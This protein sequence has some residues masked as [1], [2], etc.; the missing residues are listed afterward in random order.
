MPWGGVNVRMVAMKQATSI[1]FGLALLLP[2]LGWAEEGSDHYGHRY[3]EYGRVRVE[4]AIGDGAGQPYVANTLVSG[5]N[6]NFIVSATTGVR[7]MPIPDDEP[8][9]TS[10]YV[11]MYAVS[12]GTTTVSSEVLSPGPFELLEGIRFAST[13]FA[14][15]ASIPIE[16][17]VIFVLQGQGLPDYP[18]A[19]PP[20]VVNLK[21]YNKALYLATMEYWS[22]TQFLKPDDQ[23]YPVPCQTADVAKLVI[24]AGAAKLNGTTM[25]H[26]TV[27][28]NGDGTT[29]RESEGQNR[30][31][32]NLSLATVMFACTHG[33]QGRFRAS[34]ADEL[35]YSPTYSNEV[36]TY[37]TSKP[38]T[39]RPPRD[40]PPYNMAFFYACE[41]LAGGNNA[42]I[43]F[44]LLG[45]GSPGEVFPNKAY[46]GFAGK[47]KETLYQPSTETLE[48]H[49]ERLMSFLMQGYTV[50]DALRWTQ[51]P[52][53]NP[54]AKR[55]RSWSDGL[56]D[57]L[58]K[59]D[60]YARLVNV[61][62]S[63]AELAIVNKEVLNR[64]WWVVWQS[65]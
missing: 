32:T 33:E 40:V 10:G 51:D 21:A 42:P 20:V 52:N 25:N 59:G 12:I 19:L 8:A 57:M 31:D 29:Y 48:K 27:P 45:L 3:L 65:P 11:G 49:S 9:Y 2:G 58:V 4:A 41:T 7:P 37:V 46:L 56:I 28:D 6:V 61:Y 54:S 63:G 38:G 53:G 39:P 62:L 16:F 64:W 36:K 47:V 30:L 35:W 5:T 34:H 60:T 18:V 22:G 1:T 44:G 55:A 43:A 26:T 24:D 14:D 17:D 23:G 15:D 50:T 13:H